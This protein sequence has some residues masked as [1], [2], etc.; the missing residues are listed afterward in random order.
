MYRY[1]I[2]EACKRDRFVRCVTIKEEEK[3]TAAP[4][5]VD[6]GHGHAHGNHQPLPCVPQHECQEIYGII[7]AHFDRSVY[8][9]CIYIPWGYTGWGEDWQSKINSE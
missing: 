2:Q 1:G 7:G 8:L 9:F 3:T 5:S 4:V 6:G